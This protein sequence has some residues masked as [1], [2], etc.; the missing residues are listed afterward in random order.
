M[1]IDDEKASRVLYRMFSQS[2]SLSLDLDI[3]ASPLFS[4]LKCQ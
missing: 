2:L 1:T 3:L 4:V